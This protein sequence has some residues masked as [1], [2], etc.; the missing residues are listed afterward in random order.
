MSSY[1]TKRSSFIISK[2]KN[3]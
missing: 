1:Y 2:H 3:K